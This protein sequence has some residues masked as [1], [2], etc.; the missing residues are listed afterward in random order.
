MPILLGVAERSRPAR[1]ADL[2]TDLLAIVQAKLGIAQH[3]DSRLYPHGQSGCAKALVYAHRLITQRRARCCIVAGVDSYL[4][5]ETLDAYIDRRRLLTPSNSNASW[6]RCCF[7]HGHRSTISC[8]T[9]KR[10]LCGGG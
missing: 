2:D 8:P 4:Q 5:Q 6:N 1:L 7:W 10:S 3:P 9:R